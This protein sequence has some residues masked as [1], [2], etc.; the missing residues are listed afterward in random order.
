MAEG[1]DEKGET[2]KKS[3]TIAALTLKRLERLARRQTHGATPATVMTNFIEAGVRDAI[4][5]GYIKLEDD[6]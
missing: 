4:E 5:R 6:Q 1:D 2:L 3:V